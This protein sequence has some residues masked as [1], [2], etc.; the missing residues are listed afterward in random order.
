VTDRIIAS[1]GGKLS[2]Q[3]TEEECGQIAWGFLL[4]PNV[5]YIGLYETVSTSERSKSSYVSA[6][7][8]LPALR[9]TLIFQRC[10]CHR[11]AL[12]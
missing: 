9:A 1:P 10:A 2:A 12:D 6:R 3:L 7:I 5:L 11:Q 4:R 8:P